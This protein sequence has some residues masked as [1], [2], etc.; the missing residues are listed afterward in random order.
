[1]NKKVAAISAK[2]DSGAKVGRDQDKH[3]SIFITPLRLE[4]G[5]LMQFM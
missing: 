3:E 4:L 1:M 2:C 5:R